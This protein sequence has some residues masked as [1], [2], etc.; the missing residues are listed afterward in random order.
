MFF[1]PALAYVCHLSHCLRIS[2]VTITICV[3]CTYSVRRTT[4]V[5]RCSE[6]VTSRL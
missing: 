4:F 6:R 2:E 3:I 1:S 5:W